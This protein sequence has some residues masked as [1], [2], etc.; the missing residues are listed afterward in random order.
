MSSLENHV[1][2]PVQILQWR[3]PDLDFSKLEALQASLGRLP[4]E[5]GLTLAPVGENVAA[6]ENVSRE[7]DIR[8]LSRSPQAVERLWEVCQVPDYRKVSAQGHADLVGTLY[9]FLMENKEIPVDWFA[10]Q[11]ALVDRTDGD[12]DTLSNRIAQVRTWS[13]VANRP[14]WLNDPEHWQ[15]AARQV[16]DKLSDALHERLA[17]RFVDR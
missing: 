16:E 7:S 1:F 14:D 10:R 15:G 3:N 2:D 5:R 17:Q 11:L 8:Q 4:G 13:F 9:R 6:L 12:I